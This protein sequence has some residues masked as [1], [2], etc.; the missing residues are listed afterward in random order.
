MPREPDRESE[1]LNKL[2]QLWALKKKANSRKWKAIAQER[3]HTRRMNEPAQPLRR[4]RSEY[5]TAEEVAD[6]KNCLVSTVKRAIWHQELPAEVSSRQWLILKTDVE[7]W[8]HHGKRAPR[9]R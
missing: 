7:E 8:R 3:S 6:V 1:R 9:R 2:W 4:P 5:L